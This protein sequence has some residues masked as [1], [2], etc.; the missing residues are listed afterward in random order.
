[1]VVLVRCFELLEQ[2][3]NSPRK[4]G[5][6]PWVFIFREAWLRSLCFDFEGVPAIEQNCDAQRRETARCAMDSHPA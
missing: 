2:D 6:D 4:I 5:E 1:V 3:G